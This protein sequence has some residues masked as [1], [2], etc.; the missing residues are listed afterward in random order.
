VVALLKSNVL[1]LTLGD[2][3]SGCVQ[4]GAVSG[5]VKY[6]MVAEENAFV[7]FLSRCS[8]IGYVRSTD[9]HLAL[10]QRIVNSKGMG[11][12]ITCGWW[13]S[14]RKRHPKIMLQKTSCW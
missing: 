10:I 6:L 1:K 5:P 14:F 8:Q 7:K 9:K 4:C 12:T 2:Q 13:N 11:I 3:V